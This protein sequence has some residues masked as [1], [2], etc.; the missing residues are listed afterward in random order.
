MTAAE[1]RAPDAAPTKAAVAGLAL[2]YRLDRRVER[3]FDE[4][5]SCRGGSHTFHRDT[6]LIAALLGACPARVEA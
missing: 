2:D 4:T 5:V 1:P 6:G 3:L